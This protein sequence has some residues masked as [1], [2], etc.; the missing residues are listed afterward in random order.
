M[1]GPRDEFLSDEDLD[2]ADLTPDELIAW[3]NLW[4]RQAQ[5]T[6]DLDEARYEHGVFDRDPAVRSREPDKHGAGEV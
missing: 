5:V 3:W 6:N 2:I 4:L 1:S